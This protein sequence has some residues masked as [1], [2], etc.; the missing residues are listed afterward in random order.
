LHPP[1]S[2]FFSLPELFAIQAHVDW[3]SIKHVLIV[4]LDNWQSFFAKLPERLSPD[5]LVWV[6]VGGKCSPKISKRDVAVTDLLHRS[7]LRFSK[8]GLSKNAGANLSLSA[9]HIC[10]LLISSQL[11]LSLRISHR[12]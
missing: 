6:F 7:C 2:Q 5:V 1:I 12:S 9:A 3:L 10:G 8:C 4:D 11:I